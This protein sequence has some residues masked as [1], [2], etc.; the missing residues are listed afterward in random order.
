MNNSEITTSEAPVQILPT[1]I[2]YGQLA[3]VHRSV[4]LLVYRE[5]KPL[6]SARVLPNVCTT[7]GGAHLANVQEARADVQVT[8][9]LLSLRPNYGGR[10]VRR[11]IN[12][13]YWRA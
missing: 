3:E 10:E 7:R 2:S 6:D 12:G 1:S 13:D 4:P 8:Y 9:S 11:T 5:G